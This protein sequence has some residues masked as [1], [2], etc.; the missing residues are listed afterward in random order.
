MK[1]AGRLAPYFL[2]ALGV[3]L[4][5]IGILV[6]YIQS[7][8]KLSQVKGNDFDIAT[9][10]GVTTTRK[11][12]IEASGA[13]VE[14][15]VYEIPYDSRVKDVLIAAGG[16]TAK[17]D[18][19]YISKNINL[20]QRVVDGMKVYFPAMGESA[21]TQINAVNRLI[22]INTASSSELDTLPGIGPVTAEKI[23]NGR[24]Y[25]TLS[26]LVSKKIISRSVFDKIKDKISLN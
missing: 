26:E 25:Q 8:Q 10:S 12:Q 5:G 15:G 20:A 6:N 1:Q 16:L 17:A 22:N 11:V 19:T 3:A 2:A 14:P 18:R 24:P 9:V 23:I 21:T 13:V 4:M 7:N